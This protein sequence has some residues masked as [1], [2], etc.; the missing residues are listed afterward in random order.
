[1]MLLSSPY[2]QI[3]R[4]GCSIFTQSSDRC[5]FQVDQI[6]P[7][8][9]NIWKDILVKSVKIIDAI[10]G[11]RAASIFIHRVDGEL[12]YN[13]IG[14]LVGL[15]TERVRQWF[16]KSCRVIKRSLFSGEVRHIRRD[17]S[18]YNLI[19]YEVLKRQCLTPNQK[20]SKHYIEHVIVFCDRNRIP[21]SYQKI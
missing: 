2:I 21:V 17:A 5:A 16:Y 8:S 10:Y 14:K 11:V 6:T 1:V 9:I 4:D 7:E 3:S 15:S 18:R 19:R 20:Y 13:E 12:P